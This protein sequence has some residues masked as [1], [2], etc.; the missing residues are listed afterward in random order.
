MGIFKVLGEVALAVAFPVPYA[1]AKGAQYVYNKSKEKT[2]N[3]AYQK[4]KAEATAE[5]A[6]STESLE[7]KLKAAAAR[8]NEYKYYEEFLVAS[9]AVAISVAY[10]DGELSSEESEDMKEFIGGIAYNKLPQVIKDEIQKLF[11]N[12]PSFNDAMEF[13]KKVDR[14]KWDLFEEIIAMITLSDGVERKEE[15]AYMEAWKRYKVV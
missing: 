12:P 10:C 5:Y 6:K 4:G 9:F 8:F 2:Y 7:E 11:I 14:S 1:T 13:V 15:R 3:Q